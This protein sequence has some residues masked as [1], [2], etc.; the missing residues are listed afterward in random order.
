VT[1]LLPRSLSKARNWSDKLPGLQRETAKQ[2][3]SLRP[4]KMSLNKKL[5]LVIER[6]LLNS[7]SWPTLSSMP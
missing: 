7:S 6:I 1:L 2:L 5:R 3:R 4:N